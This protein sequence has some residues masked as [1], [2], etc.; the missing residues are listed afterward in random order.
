M[1]LVSFDGGKTGLMVQLASG[2]YV[3]DVIGSLGVFSPDDPISQG[4]LNGILKRKP[5]S[6][7][8]ALGAGANWVATTGVACN[9]SAMGVIGQ[10]G[11]APNRPSSAGMAGAGRSFIARHAVTSRNSARTYYADIPR[12]DG[13]GNTRNWRATADE[14]GHYS[15]AIPLRCRSPRCA[16]IGKSAMLCHLALR[17]VDPNNK[18]LTQAS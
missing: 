15:L 16:T 17:I 4:V 2:P 5:G 3:I 14:D 18:T 12:T 10:L 11:S 13:S 7:G 8:R 6:V 1:K 9:S